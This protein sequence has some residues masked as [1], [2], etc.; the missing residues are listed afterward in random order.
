MMR[1]RKIIILRGFAF[2]LLI[3][4]IAPKRLYPQKRPP[5]VVF[6]IA[7]IF[8]A[9]TNGDT[10]EFPLMPEET[11]IAT[12]D[13]ISETAN[14]YME[15]LRSIYSY[16]HF[17]FL[18]MIGGGF[19]IGLDTNDG[20]F[21][22][23][24]LYGVK[25]HFLSLS[26]SCKSGP[27]DGLLPIRIEVQLDT[28]TTQHQRFQS[29]NRIY[30]FKTLCT[31]KHAHPLVIGRP[32]Q[33]YKGHKEAMFIVFTPFFQQIM[34][35]D[36]YDTIV[37]NYRQVMRLTTGKS[38]LGGRRLF[39]KINRYFETKLNKETTLNYEEITAHLTAP[40]PPPP[41]PREDIPIFIPHD[42]APAPIGG[43]GSI[44]RNLKYPEVARKAGVEGRLM[45][46]AKI[47]DEGDVVQTRVMKSLGPNGCD[48][49][50]MQ[51]ISSVKWK[52]AIRGDKPISVWIAVP[53][54]F[55]LK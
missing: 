3:I 50:A 28:I 52:P 4:I 18:S 32:L 7:Y 40:P 34:Q 43:Y 10:L 30:F 23:Y 48:E 24:T 44:Q 39:K 14:G 17:S 37:A 8:E 35:G 22:T 13:N 11:A 27:K 45:I 54:V 20:I 6:Y 38:D 41:P 12:L 16:Q 2:L 42:Q 25:N 1:K 53:V 21:D 51:A 15:K 47:N 46:W 55:K 36:Q 5:T 9:K 26:A 29:K 19:T 33:F 49:A 31:V